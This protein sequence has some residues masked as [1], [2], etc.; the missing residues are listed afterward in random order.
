MLEIFERK[1][2]VVSST[3]KNILTTQIKI[4]SSLIAI[5]MLTINLSLLVGLITKQEQ[6][7]RLLSNLVMAVPD[8]SS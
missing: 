3:H 8:I 2:F 6:L 5:V 7:K 4:V 1:F